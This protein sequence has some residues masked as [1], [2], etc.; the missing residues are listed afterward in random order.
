[1]ARPV[2]RLRD[3][4]GTADDCRK[5]KSQAEQVTARAGLPPARPKE[6]I[7]KLA[8]AAA[9]AAQGK[10]YRDFAAKIGATAVGST[11]AEFGTFLKAEQARWKKVIADAQ[12]KVE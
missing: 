6:I 2:C 8:G 1:M 12:I 9:K 7:D 4:S 3:T 11:P 5:R 10:A